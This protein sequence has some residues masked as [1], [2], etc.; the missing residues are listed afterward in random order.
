MSSTATMSNSAQSVTSNGMA[1]YVTGPPKRS[2]TAATAVPR[3]SP[4]RALTAAIFPAR[5]SGSASSSWSRSSTLP[6][7]V[8][9]RFMMLS[10]TPVTN[11]TAAPPARSRSARSA[12]SASSARISAG[13][14]SSG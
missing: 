13:A 5:R 9:S 7:G 4:R 6:P 12:Q 10:S 14:S 1:A 11:T 3:N 8:K 2:R